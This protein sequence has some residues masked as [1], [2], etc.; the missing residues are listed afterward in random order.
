[1]SSDEQATAA[2]AGDQPGGETPRRSTTKRNLIVLIVA[3]V[4]LNV[5]A[6][7]VAPPFPRDGHPGDAC[8][9]PVCYINGTL[10]LPAPHTVW[11]PEGAEPAGS[12]LIVFAPSLSSTLVT[13][14]IVSVGILIVGGLAARLKAPVPGFIQNFTEWSYESL[15]N[16]GTGL[17]GA[18]AKPYLPIFIGAF[19]LIL[20]SNWS[21]LLP[22]VGR[23]EF[24]R[25]PTSDVNVTLGFALVAWLFFEA[26]GFRKLGIGGYLSKFLPLYEFKKGI[27]AG[28]IALFVGLTE[29][30]L[31]FVK[32]LTLSMRLF[33]NIFGGEVAL[34]V[35]SA[36]FLAFIF[37][38]ALYS[39][40]V[41]LNLVQALIFSVLTLIFTVLAIESHHHEEGEIGEET[42][43]AIHE[44][45]HGEPQPAA[46]H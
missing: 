29:L 20:I 1:M 45:M 24:L 33:G 46:A 15:A 22:I 41:V 38:V 32:P 42:V 2:M 19:V 11:A 37:P 10:E 43:E 21:G 12:G 6:I 35:F 3:I 40:E 34:G 44:G 26:E 4:V 8:A 28:A 17:A 25:A 39:L 7:I 27:S 23:V 9:Y 5:V 18:A 16:F 13:L 14:F 31:E 30:L 36:L